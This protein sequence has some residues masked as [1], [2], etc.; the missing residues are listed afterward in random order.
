NYNSSW[1]DQ[2]ISYGEIDYING[3]PQVEVG[4]QT[5][6]Y[7]NQGNPTTITNFYYDGDYYDH[8]DLQYDGRQLNR[9]TIYEEGVSVPKCIISYQYNDQGYRTSKKIDKITQGSQTIEYFLQGDKV[10]F[11]TDGI[12]GIIYTYDYDGT[13]ISFNYDNIVGDSTDGIEYFYIRNQQGDITKIVDHNGGIVV[14]YEYDAWGNITDVIE[15][16]YNESDE[17]V[18]C[19]VAEYIISI[20]NPYRYRGYRFDE[21]I[22]LYYLNSRYYDANIGRFINADGLLGSFGDSQSTN[23]YAYAQNNPIMMIDESGYFTI[24]QQIGITIGVAA[25]CTVVIVLAATYTGAAA[26][27]IIGA[28]AGAGS[29]IISNA[30][31]NNKLGDNVAGAAIGGASVASGHFWIAGFINAGINQGENLIKNGEF[32]ISTL[33][34]EGFSY[35]LLNTIRITSLVGKSGQALI[36]AGLS[37]LTVDGIGFT[38]TEV[39]TNWIPDIVISYNGEEVE[40]EINGNTVFAFD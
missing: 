15:Y 23:M 39:I 17:L 26:P 16:K 8:A 12:Y 19:D 11:E 1:K 22:S 7:D 40:L 5:Y 20:I 9:I 3:V 38:A 24:W 31:H 13:L 30:W 29:Q 34:I 21:E 35:S 33:V 25:A 27:A 14:E 37:A 28:T 32:N 6:T 4:L 10:L 18:E 36:R 2:L